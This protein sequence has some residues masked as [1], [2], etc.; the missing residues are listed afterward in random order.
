MRVVW[1]LVSRGCGCFSRAL[2]RRLC[3]RCAF[4]WLC[5]LGLGWCLAFVLRWLAYPAGCSCGGFAA[6][7]R[8]GWLC[9]FDVGWCSAFVLRWCV[10]PA[11]C[12][13]GGSAAGALLGG[14]ASRCFCGAAGWALRLTGLPCQCDCVGPSSRA[15]ALVQ[16]RAA[17]AL[18][19]RAMGL[20]GRECPA[21]VMAWALYL[22][23]MCPARSLGLAWVCS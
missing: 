7:A 3:R 16:L 9:R 15:D 20:V 13:C 12:C 22:L 1:A 5:R 2:L 11:W 21:G 19:V 6:G 17:A 14:C 4:G 23:P 8:L 18:V 10:Y